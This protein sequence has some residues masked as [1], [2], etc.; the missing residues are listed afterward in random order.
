MAGSRPSL[1][2]SPV[3][4]PGPYITF[5][6]NPHNDRYAT[7]SPLWARSRPKWLE[8]RKGR[9][10]VVMLGLRSNVI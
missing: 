5:D 7:L 10:A 1:G 9:V 6:R 4:G 3:D 2:P 8:R